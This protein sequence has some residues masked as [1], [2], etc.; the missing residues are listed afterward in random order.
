ML[1]EWDLNDVDTWQK[2]KDEK[3]VGKALYCLHSLFVRIRIKGTPPI[4]VAKTRH[5]CDK[6]SKG[7][8]FGSAWPQR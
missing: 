2:A 4:I 8:D 1:D 5:S 3:G 6:S 7:E